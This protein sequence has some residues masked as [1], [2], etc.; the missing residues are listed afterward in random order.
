[1]ATQPTGLPH[2]PASKLVVP[3]LPAEFSPRPRLRHLLDR[4]AADQV[5]VLSAPGGSGK[6]L[7]LAD[8]V[9]SG[10]GPETAWISIDVDDNDPRQLWA[11]VVTALLAVPSVAADHRLQRL[12]TEVTRERNADVVDALAAALDALDPPVRLVLDD[13]HEL[14]GPEVLRDLARLVRLRPAGVRLVLA[15]RLDPPISVPRLR[16]EGRLHELR[17]DVLRFTL[18]DTAALLTAAGLQLT[19][20]QVAG[21]HVRTDGWVAGLRLA[22]LALR[23]TEDPDGF[24]T[25]F[26]GDE[27]SVADYL[28]GEILAGL[29]ADTRT[30]L[31]AVSVCSLLPGAGRRAALASVQFLGRSEVAPGDRSNHRSPY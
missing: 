29:S 18:D 8:W 10:E 3:E 5:I 11:A 16:L 28:T 21:L 12:L 9:R 15:S 20:A 13:V 25:A 14:I 26:S 7:L 1:M 31:R 24:L 4:A 23:R 22:A 17:V 6:T 30:F 2:V 27:R 19:P